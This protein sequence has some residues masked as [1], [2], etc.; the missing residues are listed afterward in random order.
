MMFD[1]LRIFAK[2]F[3]V[4]LV[5][6]TVFLYF[7]AI[8]LEPALFYFTPEGLS[9]SMLH[10]SVLQV[11]VLNMAIDI[12]IRLEVGVIFFGL[13][14]IFTLS[15]VAAWKVKESF[16]QTIKESITKPTR[17]LFNNCL[18]AMPI[19]NSMTLIAVVAL[20]SVQEAGGIPTGTSP[21][22]SDLFVEFL[23]LSYAAVFEEIGFRLIPIG[24]ILCIY[25]FVT[26]K[27]VATFSLRQKTKLFVMSFLFPDKAKRMAGAKTVKEHGI[28]NGISLVEWGAIIF[29]SVI[30]GLAHF[31]PG[32][33]WEIG[34][35]TSAGFA[36]LVLGLSYVVYGAQA[37]IIMH[38]FFNVYTDTYIL[39]SELYPATLPF[40]NT[41]TIISVILGVLGWT[42][43]AALGF[44][45]L[46]RTIEKRREKN[47]QN[48]TTPSP[49]IFPQQD[50]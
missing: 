10:S 26:K 27:N 29:T 4:V 49:P 32:V 45:K 2:M 44:L 11:W 30:F 5:L 12:P 21:I 25:L 13:W 24:A 36:G 47:S 1:A 39:L 48:Q 7:L 38:W 15:L 50:Y 6:F 37:S 9:T 22:Q 20:Q 14:S 17:K 3:L 35:V 28:R 8:V 31:D 40:A 16:P 19:I 43:A 46:V 41:V 33:S 18:F 34:K 23:D 42:I